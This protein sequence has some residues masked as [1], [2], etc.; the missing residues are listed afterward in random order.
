M[1][2]SGRV[3][4]PAGDWRSVRGGDGMMP[5]PWMGAVIMLGVLAAFGLAIWH[6]TVDRHGTPPHP[7]ATLGRIALTLLAVAAAMY[8]SSDRQADPGVRRGWTGIA[9]ALLCAWSGQVLLFVAPTM[10][11]PTWLRALGRGVLVLFYPVCLMALLCWPQAPRGRM[12]RVMYFMDVAIV[13]SAAAVVAWHDLTI[14]GVPAESVSGAAILHAMVAGDLIALLTVSMLWQRS[15]V[16][17]RPSTWNAAARP[18]VFLA[19]AL[20]T[21]FIADLGSIILGHIATP[22][23]PV[24]PRALRPL[25]IVGI[26]IAAW[27][28]VGERAATGAIEQSESMVVRT[29]AIP[30]IVTFP[31]FAVLLLTT[32]EYS[33]GPVA[34]LVLGA[35]LLSVLAFVRVGVATR[36]AMRA[37]ARSAARDGEARFQ[38]LVQ[39]TNDL[40]VILDLDTTIRWISPS[41]SRLFA[42]RDT[43]TIGRPLLDLIHAEDRPVA[44]RFL[45]TL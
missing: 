44:E 38:A 33:A 8:A 14:R 37:M 12:A 40:I 13:A 31:C 26:A 28:Q 16:G 20:A 23:S 39:H 29:S 15:G 7:G 19:A 5:A 22:E 43:D 18:L 32:T 27:A 11:D 6:V 35:A 36:E 21:H 2:P 3:V 41:V 9:L 17:L 25:A 1:P 10:G 24:W 34:G 45:H 30:V 4:T 42:L